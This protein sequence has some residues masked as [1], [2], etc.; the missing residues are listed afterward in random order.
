MVYVLMPFQGAYTHEHK[1]QG[2]ALGYVLL[3]FQPV[4]FQLCPHCTQGVALGYALVGFGFPFGRRF[5]IQP[6]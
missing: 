3:G 5:S 2:V 4:A 6:V 1:T